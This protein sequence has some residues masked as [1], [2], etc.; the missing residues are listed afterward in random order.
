[1]DTPWQK[2]SVQQEISPDRMI[3]FS[4]GVF[5]FAI[6][7]L[8]LNIHVPLPQELVTTKKTLLET[9]REQWPTYLSFLLSFL[10][11]GIVWGN[12]HTM[13]SYIKRS[14]HSLVVLNLLLLLGIVVLPFVAALLALYIGTPEQQTAILVYSG[15]WAIG[16][17]FY[18]LLWWYASWKH[19]LLDRNLPQQTVRR[20]TWRYLFGPLLYLLAFGVSFFWNGIVGLGL[21]MLL[22][23]A[24]LLPTVAD[25]VRSPV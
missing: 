16:G 4:D 5:A 22:A 2:M 8:I 24:Y 9:L 13:F 3:A 18:N 10:I 25:R 19:R 23:I 12:H 11:V 21:C 20:L 1:M 15:V 17:I 6:T 7:L 14:N